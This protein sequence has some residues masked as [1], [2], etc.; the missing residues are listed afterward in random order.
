MMCAHEAHLVS[1][2]GVGA[3]R[4]YFTPGELAFPFRAI[5]RVSSHVR[6]VRTQCTCA[7][8]TLPPP[9]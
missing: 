4:R 5:Q 3:V 7:E 2:T 8:K 6:A 1:D 9:N